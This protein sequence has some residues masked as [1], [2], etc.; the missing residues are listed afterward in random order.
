MT[1]KEQNKLNQTVV[2]LFKAL[3]TKGESTGG[4][5]ALF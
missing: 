1:K 5:T 2:A 4:G 3:K